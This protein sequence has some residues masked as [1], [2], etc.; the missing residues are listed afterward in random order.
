MR[1]THWGR[2]LDHIV[3]GSGCW[4]RSR[5]SLQ[6]GG[7][8]DTIGA[9]LPEPQHPR[10]GGSLWACYCP[11][12]SREPQNQ[13]G[14]SRLSV[15]SCVMGAMAVLRLL[16]VWGRLLGGPRPSHVPK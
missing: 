15:H 1:G 5:G 2:H 10:F 12:S 16:L 3:Q 11:H 14:T 8:E 4:A 6:V 13:R 9:V 7:S